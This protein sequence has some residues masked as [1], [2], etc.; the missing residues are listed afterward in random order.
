VGATLYLYLRDHVTMIGQVYQ[1]GWNFGTRWWSGSDCNTILA[2]PNSSAPERTSTI[3]QSTQTPN[4]FH[5][6]TTYEVHYYSRAYLPPF[7][8]TPSTQCRI[9]DASPKVS[10]RSSTFFAPSEQQKYKQWRHPEFNTMVL[11]YNM[12]LL[13]TG[14]RLRG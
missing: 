4:L 11:D 14:F 7:A 13:P 2:T 12:V 6:H 5:T 1:S 3:T 9:M 10:P 8:P